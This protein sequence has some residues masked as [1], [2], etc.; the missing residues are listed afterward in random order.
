MNV[1]TCANFFK[2]Q[3]LCLLRFR[4]I[5]ILIEQN[6]VTIL[7]HLLLE[8]RVVHFVQD[9]LE[10]PKQELIVFPVIV[11]GHE[12]D[13]QLPEP[14]FLRHHYKKMV[15][16]KIKINFILTLVLIVLPQKLQLIS[17]FLQFL[18]QLP[19][20]FVLSD[21]NVLLDGFQLFFSD[22]DA[23]EIFL[24]AQIVEKSEHLG[25]ADASGSIGVRTRKSIL[26]II[27]T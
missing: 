4:H 7:F 19:D 3:K 1:K 12:L 18:L 10:F 20:F 27:L 6:S 24:S 23:L 9:I 11:S 5:F 17:F 26:N 16:E 22:L 13:F 2:V 8:L 14:K 25:P 15:L 21:L